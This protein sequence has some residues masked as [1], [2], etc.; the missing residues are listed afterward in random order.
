MTQKKII[1]PPKASAD[2]WVQGTEVPLD[3]AEPAEPAALAKPE[4]VK[5]S[6]I[7]SSPQKKPSKREVRRVT[8]DISAEL[9]KRLRLAA[10]EKGVP[11]VSII[12]CIV[13]KNL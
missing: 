7:N 5:F 1:I 10:A 3:T 12:E 13:E 11:M 8:L 4:E 6:S 2:S 9:H